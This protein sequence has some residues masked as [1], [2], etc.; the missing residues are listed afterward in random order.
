[1]RRIGGLFIMLSIMMAQDST[2]TFDKIYKNRLFTTAKMEQ[3]TWFPG[4]NAYLITQ[5]DT[6]NNG[7]HFYKVDIVDQDTTLFIPSDVTSG[8]DAPKMM[9]NFSF[10]LD[11]KKLLAQTSMRKIWR[12]SRAGQFI[13]IDS[14]TQTIKSI[15]P[16]EE[17][18][19]AKFSP[20][21]QYIAY[22][23]NDN[24][25][26]I[27]DLNKDKEKQITKDGS[28]TILNGHPGWV[29]EEEFR[30]YDGYRWSPDSK[31]IAFWREDQS[32]VKQFHMIHEMEI[33]SEVE[34]IYYPK[35]GET[36]PVMKIG[37]A[38]LKWGRIR[39]MDLGENTDIYIPK[40]DWVAA[41]NTMDG[42]Q[43]LVI[44]WLNRKQ[45]HLELWVTDPKTGQHE[46]VYT[47][48]DTCFIELTNNTQFLENGEILLTSERSGF[49]HL[50]KINPQTK[51]MEQI[52]NGDWDVS[53]IV[54]LKDENVYFY[55]AKDGATNRNLYS[56][57]LEGGNVK[58]LTVGDGRHEANFAPLGDVFVHGHSAWDKAPVIT[59]R[60]SDGEAIRV[61]KETDMT[62]YKDYGFV[63]PELMKIPTPD[64]LE[65]DG[66]IMKPSDFDPTKKYPIIINGY[67]M[68]G[69]KIVNNYWSGNLRQL[70]VKK[71]F[72]VFAFD[73]RHQ[74]GYGKAR[75][76]L[77]YGDASKWLIQDH[78]YAID[79]LGSLGYVDTSRV[80]AWGWSGGGYFTVMALT[81]AP[82][83][84]DVGVAVASVT[85]WKYYDTIWTERYMNTPQDNPNGYISSSVFTYAYQL[86][87]KLLMIHGSTDDNV[88]TQNTTVL[89]N[90]FVRLG[91]DVDVFIYPDRNH[92]IYGGGATY[93]VFKQL[94]DYFVENL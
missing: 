74:S 93:H 32:M 26:Y 86:K 54:F 87:G 53:E 22:V 6:S 27:W 24:N 41:E 66:M 40:M 9:M 69:T 83:Y 91:K 92:G 73:S 61:L 3:Y 64:G 58:R 57:S 78:K 43:K 38:S 16:G 65:L 23:K 55:G 62:L 13:V 2:L 19:N 76:N 30:L 44:T 36:N 15:A 59:L 1:M 37:V 88:H 17:L 56:I 45:N 67:G 42:K 20:N 51:N 79:Y 80:G 7:K 35:A 70:L 68:P 75:I 81:K 12:H 25:L 33:Y 34:S 85:D 14:E 10:S 60:Q 82:E 5:K 71:G 28:E 89:V 46:V 50:Y 18:R 52:T 4:E 77:G 72:I 84:F 39:W 63:A 90:E 47:D 49:Q 21:S 48:D 29:Y 8:K 31:A 94:V 11:G